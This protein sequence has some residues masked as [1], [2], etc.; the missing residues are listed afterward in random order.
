MKKFGISLLFFLFC[1]TIYG[2]SCSI[3]L[4]GSILD[5]HDKSSLDDANIYLLES[6]QG[7]SSDSLGNFIVENIGQYIGRKHP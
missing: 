7:A 6:Q 4:S 5:L 2:Q 1:I 3:K